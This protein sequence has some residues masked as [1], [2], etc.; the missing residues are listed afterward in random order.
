MESSPD[1][2]F[3]SLGLWCTLPGLPKD[4]G[5]ALE[6]VTGAAKIRPGVAPFLI[7]RAH[8]QGHSPLC[9]VATTVP[10]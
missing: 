2:P 4:P 9:G 8:R 5:M 10:G 3:D 1:P 7:L 6:K